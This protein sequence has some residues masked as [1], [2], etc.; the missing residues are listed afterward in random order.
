MKYDKLKIKY[1]E[2]FPD[3]DVKFED[4]YPLKTNNGACLFTQMCVHKLTEGGV[5][6]IV[7]PD[8]ELFN[9]DK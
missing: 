2:N 8:G 7:L 9:G 3:S 6:A 4:I 5:C 1:E